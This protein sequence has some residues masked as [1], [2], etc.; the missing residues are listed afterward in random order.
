MKQQAFM[1][2]REERWLEFRAQL[3]ALESGRKAGARFPEQYRLVCQDLALARERG[4]A[5]SLV[6][7]LNGLAVRGHQH[8]YGARVGRAHPVEFLA[9][10]FPA[11]VRREARLFGVMS[12]LLYGSALLIFFLDLAHPS[13]VYHLLSADQ[14]AEFESMYDPAAP[15]YGAP[16]ETVGDLNAFAFYVSNNIGVALRTFAWGLFA[17]VGSLF[18]V[19]FNGVYAGVVAAHITQVGFGS[20][21]FPFIIGHGSFELTAIVLAGVTG[22]KLGWTLVAPGRFT[23]LVAL[24]RAARDTVPLLYGLIA[25]L[26]VAA[27]LEAFWSSSATVP[28]NAKLGVGALLWL[29]VLGWL[30]LGGRQRAD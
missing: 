13:L 27:V 17:G 12:L 28:A 19:V 24:R 7:R 1:Q 2:A 14:V 15:H 21:F 26:L 8:L 11:A 23:R 22:M 5:T 29:L 6:D 3:E 16:R 10:R 18:L 30:T 9:R 20:T 25:M 4:F